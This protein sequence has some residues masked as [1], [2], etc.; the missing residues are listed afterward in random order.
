[1]LDRVQS[2]TPDQ[3]FVGNIFHKIHIEKRTRRC[4]S[5][6][7]TGRFWLKFLNGSELVIALKHVGDSIT[8][9]ALIRPV[10]TLHFASIFIEWAS[11][12]YVTFW[13][14]VILLILLSF[15][16][17]DNCNAYDSP[18]WLEIQARWLLYSEI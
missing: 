4:S 5:P 11:I 3:H 13:L 17:Y 10:E 18:R 8:R 2:I 15:Q 12:Y 9:Q 6:L 16:S 7:Y 1:M 14:A